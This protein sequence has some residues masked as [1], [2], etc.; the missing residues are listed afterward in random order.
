MVSYLNQLGCKK[1]FGNN[2]TTFFRPLRS[3]CGLLPKEASLTR[4]R[5]VVSFAPPS[6]FLLAAADRFFLAFPV[7]G[8][9]LHSRKTD[10]RRSYSAY[11]MIVA[12]CHV[13]TI[14]YMYV[15]ARYKGFASICLYLFLV[16]LR[17]NLSIRPVNS[18]CA[19]YILFYGIA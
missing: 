11:Q 14:Y 17:L 9:E 18:N 4:S 8:V 10:R 15:Q 7:A 19:M 6:G 12:Q 2:L 3:S 16:N 5:D 1:I 13:L